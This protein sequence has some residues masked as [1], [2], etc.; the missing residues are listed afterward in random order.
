M[1]HDWQ[2]LTELSRGKPVIV[3]RVRLVEN[4]IAVEGEF[5]LPPLARLTSEDQVF[6]MAFIKCEGTIKEMEKAFGVSYPTIKARLSKISAQM[7]M[8]EAISANEPVSEKEKSTAGTTKKKT[9]RE[10]VIAALE[11]GEISAAEAI[12]RLSK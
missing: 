9:E 1:A 4:N 6:V 2:E 11:K 7:P 5:E 8:V 12:E 10:S 3:E